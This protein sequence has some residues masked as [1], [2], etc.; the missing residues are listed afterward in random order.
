M[1]FKPE[2]DARELPKFIRGVFEIVPYGLWKRR[3]EVLREQANSNPFLA[4]YFAS[5]FFL[6]R[7]FEAVLRQHK[8][9]GRYPRV[10][11]ETYDVYSFLAMLKLVNDRLST[12]GRERLRGNIRDAVMTGLA[13]LAA[14]FGTATHLMARNF[15]V[16]FTDLEGLAQF[17]FLASQGDFQIE[18][19]CKAASGDIGRQIHG[20]RFRSFANL[21]L[22]M[23]R[24]LSNKPGAGTL[25]QMTIPGN[26]HGAESHERDL[27]RNIEC[28]I[29]G[30][31][32]GEDTDAGIEI[33]LQSFELSGTPFD[34]KVK[35]FRRSYR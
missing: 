9:T 4:D 11:G 27:V 20:R 24:E 3:F 26:L 22:P 21:L 8:S 14:E 33:S 19:D 17:D 1:W 28:A 13:P 23:V 18:I 29:R 30:K 15:D 34:N 7:S 10:T 5:E 6:E 25:L 2:L 35:N 12:K 16:Q 32:S 31:V